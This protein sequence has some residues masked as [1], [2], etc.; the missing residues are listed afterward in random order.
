MSRLLLA[1]LFG[2]LALPALAQVPS[3][4]PEAGHAIAKTWCANCHSVEP[5]AAMQSA[6]GVPSF[7]AVANQTSTTVMSLQAFLQTPHARM[8]NFQLSHRQIEDVVAYIMTLK[9]R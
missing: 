4:D 1:A 6:D 9:G 3:G 5:G 8:P 7:P 2:L